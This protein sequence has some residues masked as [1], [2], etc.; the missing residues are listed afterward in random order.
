V[1]SYRVERLERKVAFLARIR[2][3]VIFGIPTVAAL[4]WLIGLN[5]WDVR[6]SFHARAGLSTLFVF[7]IVCVPAAIV[8]SAISAVVEQ[9]LED[10]RVEDRLPEARARLSR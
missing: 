5:D 8:H 10:V 4:I 1:S 7:L 9:R 2:T 3:A 6:L